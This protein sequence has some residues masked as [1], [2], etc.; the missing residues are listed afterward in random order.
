MI[1]LNKNKIVN[2]SY[3]FNKHVLYTIYKLKAK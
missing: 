3:T 2:T 1:L